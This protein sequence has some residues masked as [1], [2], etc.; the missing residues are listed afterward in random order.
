VPPSPD[1]HHASDSTVGRRLLFTLALLSALGPLAIDAY[2]PGFTAMAKD[3]D[4]PASTVQLPLSCTCRTI[5]H[6]VPVSPS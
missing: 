1:S 4:T 3:L 5:L 2:L 6:P